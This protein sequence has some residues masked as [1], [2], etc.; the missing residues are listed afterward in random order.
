M[1]DVKTSMSVIFLTN[2]AEVN[3][4]KIRHFVIQSTVLNCSTVCI[5]DFDLGKIYDYI[6]SLLTTFEVFNIFRGNWGNSENWLEPIV[7][8]PNQVKLVQIP[9]T[10]CSLI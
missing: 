5:R 6:G 9:D 4:S 10:H 1:I 2:L 7:K 8:P 3:P